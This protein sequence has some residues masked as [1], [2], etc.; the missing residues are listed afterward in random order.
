MA[1]A[2]ERSA[3]DAVAEAGANEVTRLLPPSAT[4]MFPSWS[5][6][7]SLAAEKVLAEANGNE[8]GLGRV[9]VNVTC[10]R[11]SLAGLP[12]ETFGAKIRMRLSSGTLT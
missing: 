11:T 9:A 6:F 10:P 3:R 5:S 12:E 4:Y 2:D 8:D 7:T 1:R